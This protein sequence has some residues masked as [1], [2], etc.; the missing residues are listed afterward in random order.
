MK[1]SLIIPAFNEE[2]G[3]PLVIEE[4]LGKVDEIIVVDD[5]ST[6]KTF[7][8]AQ[9][10]ASK[11]VRVIKHE[12]NKGKLAA[13]RTGIAAAKGDIIILTDADYTYPAK[14]LPR[15]ISEIE[16]GAD[17]VIGS[18]FM[19]EG[20]RDIP[21]LNCIGNLLFSFLASYI[22]CLNL[23]DAQS[24]Y[25]AFRKRD[26][27]KL[28]VKAKSLEFETKQTVKAAKLG[29]KIVEF[30]ID[31]RPRV[32]QSK[33]NPLI[34]GYKMFRSILSVAWRETSLLGK[35]IILPGGLFVLFS[36]YFGIVSLYERLTLYKLSHEYYPLL[37]VFFFLIALQLVSMGLLI[38][39]L[40]KKLDRIEE[41]LQRIQS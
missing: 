9:R 11:G 32:G 29:Y 38:D 25:R 16:N 33:L 23:T 13:I 35:T 26:F 34:D 12:H 41:R 7:E 39:H 27:P 19:G 8:V 18:R 37:A 4:A 24:G 6:D 5:G 2:K 10:Y 20:N 22:S 15:F 40:T 21:F 14:Y 3:L 31:Y 1:S 28:D 30:P 17:L 36:F